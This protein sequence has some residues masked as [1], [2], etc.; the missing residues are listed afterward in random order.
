MIKLQ[1][2]LLGTAVVER[3]GTRQVFCFET[4]AYYEG[5]A[6]QDARFTPPPADLTRSEVWI[7]SGKRGTG[8]PSPSRRRRRKVVE[9]RFRHAV[10]LEAASAR[11]QR[12]I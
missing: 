8:H 4:H 5:V 3:D 2:P 7:L 10:Q 12:R 9:L 1:D 11:L 6:N